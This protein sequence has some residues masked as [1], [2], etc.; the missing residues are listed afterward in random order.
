MTDSGVKRCAE[1][2]QPNWAT[3]E[4]ASVNFGDQ[5]LNRRAAR[6]L[7]TLGAKPT[8]S[9]PA[10][11]KGWS[12][13]QAAYRFFAQE[14]VTAQEILAPHTQC[15]LE[16]ARGRSVVLAI[17]D[18]SELDYTSKPGIVGLGPLT[19]ANQHGLHI[20][21]TLMVTPE[22]V[23]LGVF[24]AWNWARDPE[25]FG[26]DRGPRP[27][28]EKESIR[29]LEGYQRVCEAQAELPTTRLV[30]VAD[31][32]G[33]IYELFAEAEKSGPARAE[34]LIRANQNRCLSDGHKLWEQAA[35]APV[36]GE[37]TFTMPA[38][39]TRAAREVT[40]TLRA[41]AVVIKA[42]SGKRT[43]APAVRLTAVLAREEAP[44]KGVEAIQWLLLT[45]CAVDTFEQAGEILSWY[46][47]RWAIELFFKILKSGCKVEELQL[48]HL[49]RLEP[50]LAMYM[51][52]AWRVL[53]LTTLGRACPDLPCDVVFETE[54]WR[55]AYT[56][57]KKAPPPTTPPSLGE[58]VRIVAGFGGY[59]NRKHDGF[60]GS[61]TLWIGLQRVQ[62]FA[63]ALA[64]QHAS[65]KRRYV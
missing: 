54:E 4:M 16:R 59:L 1:V 3:R 45:T 17:Q 7:D 26:T 46:L 28:E 34:L 9:I 12:E 49:D 58:M 47:A 39:K 15:T 8:V 65:Q 50:A 6:V 30:Y 55:A 10:A 40:Q 61:Q 41:A 62:D 13:T 25:A 31:R 37:I 43:R 51:I 56:V 52:V 60:P 42:P 57:A 32:E 22:R 64:A 19:Y 24:D 20:H 36:L 11:C 53:L 38:T 35:A 44:P 27:I 63:L 33:D 48:E 21:P 29:W 2:E 14:R 5:R 18:T 23:P